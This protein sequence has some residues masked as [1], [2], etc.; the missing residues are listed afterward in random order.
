MRQDRRVAPVGPQAMLHRAAEQLPGEQID[1]AA[2]FYARGEVGKRVVRDA[3]LG[4]TVLA[5]PPD[6]PIAMVVAVTPSAV[7]VLGSYGPNRPLVPMSVL[8]VG[9]Y[10][11][12]S[13]RRLAVIDLTLN[14]S[15]RKE[16]AM[17]TKRWG[18]NRR[19]RAVVE[20]ILD[21]ANS[22]RTSHR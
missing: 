3:N 17:E 8:P 6:G 1:G 2:L 10:S 9:S 11:A 4:S 5:S 14:A 13:R 15:D 19:N 20:L 22:V 12:S 16:L 21:R 7:H 18:A